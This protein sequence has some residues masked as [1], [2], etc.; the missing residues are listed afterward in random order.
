MAVK[1]GNGTPARTLAHMKDPSL[2][3]VG[4]TRATCHSCGDALYYL[5]W[6][7]AATSHRPFAWRSVRQVCPASTKR[8][9]SDHSSR[10]GDSCAS[11][12]RRHYKSME[13]G[14]LADMEHQP[15]LQEPGLATQEDHGLLTSKPLLQPDVKKAESAAQSAGS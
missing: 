2:N 12:G 13:A 14:R 15:C 6:A 1:R 5:P 8:C 3:A 4:S 11:A 10:T 9:L 7:M